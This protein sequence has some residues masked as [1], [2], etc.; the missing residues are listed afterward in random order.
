MALAN[1]LVLIFGAVLLSLPIVLHLLM[2]RKPQHIVFPALFFVQERKST[3]QRQLNLRHFLLLALRCLL[4]LAGALALAGFSTATNLAGAWMTAGS[5]GL[6]ALVAGLL[7]AISIF[8]VRPIRWPLA[9]LFGAV[10]SGLLLAGGTY[11]FKAL[12]DGENVVISN[13][14]APVAAALIFESGPQME[15]V[16]ENESRL[17]KAKSIGDWLLGELTVDS[18]VAIVDSETATPFFNVDV[19]AARKRMESLKTTFLPISISQQIK[20]AIELLR[21][22]ELEQKELYFF[23]D[24]TNGSWQRQ[25]PSSI[26]EIIEKTKG[27]NVYLIDVGVEK[28]TNFAIKPLELGAESVSIDGELTIAGTLSRLGESGTRTIQMSLQ[29]QGYPVRR[30][31]NTILPNS[32]V[33]QTIE[34]AIDGDS[35]TPFEFK[36]SNLPAGLHFGK[37]SLVGDDG[38]SIDDSQSFSI[39]VDGLQKVIVASPENVFDEEVRDLL[40]THQQLAIETETM[41]QVDLGRRSLDGDAIFVLNPKP[42]SDQT[43][44]RLLRYVEDGGELFISL[45]HNARRSPNELPAADEFVGDSAKE[46]FPATP[47]FAFLRKDEP[48]YFAPESYSHPIVRPMQ[49][50]ANSFRWS[51]LPIRQFWGFSAENNGFES[52][53]E[54]NDGRPILIEKAIGKGHVTLLGTPITEPFKPDEDRER[55]NDLMIDQ[56]ARWP[57]WWLIRNIVEHML[58]NSQQRLNY[59][60]GETTSI[61]NDPEEDAKTYQLFPPSNGEPQKVTPVENKINYQFM[62]QPGAYQLKGVKKSGSKTS[63]V[64]KGFSAT[65]DPLQL[66]LTRIPPEM[67]DEFLG[68]E[69]YQLAKDRE[70][71]TREQ[72]SVRRGKDFYPTLVMLLIAF[73]G[74]EHLMANWFYKR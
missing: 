67:I 29:E 65:V 25:T 63:L 73:V 50:Y 55:W 27:L 47:N 58:S 59:R 18:K 10:F 42:L 17:E 56:E 6:G 32:K 36:L 74:L 52:I 31:D 54:L 9:I 15:F 70:E 51:D 57:T 23:T 20:S 41:K 26:R 72:G 22:D 2:Q 3:N 66:D 38:L 43:V 13:E 45:G 39:R 40:E 16:F 46:L 69:N 11:A 37:V 61:V 64:Q 12:K 62:N 5:F 4:I 48:V 33:A 71:I 34:V 7:F 44:N 19:S 28:A 35:E 49:S 14:K 53:I 24:L 1:P 21:D 8:T 30:G 60:V 68:K